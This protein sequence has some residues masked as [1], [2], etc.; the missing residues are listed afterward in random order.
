MRNNFIAITVLAA[1]FF[2]GMPAQAAEKIEP[3]AFE[4]WAKRAD[5]SNV[6]L[7]PD[8]EKLA[9]LKIPTKDGNPILEIY[10]ASDLTA[11]P[12]KMNANPMEMTRFYW[13]T[14]DSIIFSAR[15]QVRDKIDGFNRGVYETTRGLLT[16]DKDPK[17]S[18]WTKIASL[19]S[20]GGG[21]LGPIEAKP[22]KFLTYQYDKGSYY[23]KYFEYDVETG[24][25]KL[26]TRETPKVG[27]FRFDGEGNP[28][29]ASGYDAQSNEFLSYY[30]KKGSN[31]WEVINR[32]HRE[33]FEDWFALG[34]DPLAPSNLLVIAH[35]GENTAG[36]WSFDPENGE[37]KELIYR[38]SDV[39]LTFRGGG[40][41]RHTNRYTNPNEVTAVQYFD[42]RDIKYEWFDGDEKAL[43]EQLMGLIPHADRMNIGSR[44]RDGNSIVVSNS[45]PRDPGTYYLIKNGELKLIG[46]RKPQFASERL[47][48]AEA[49]T[50]KARDG[51]KI[52][53][54]ITIPNGKPPYPLVVMPHGGPFVSKISGYD[55]WA[56]L[57]ANHGY[58]VFEPQYRGSTGYGLDFYQ[59]AFING[60]E[61]GYKMQDDKDDGALYLVDQ[62]LADPEQLAM[63][64]WSYG[65]YAALIAAA[66]ED[67][68]YQCAIAGAAVADNIQQ[69]NYYRNRMAM[70]PTAGSIEQI[71]M[72]EESISPINE[73]KNVNIPLFVIHGDVDQRVPPM[74][75]KKYIK[76]LEENQ[77]PHKKM[78]LK[79]A[80][81]FYD[82]LFY[83]HK[84]KF[85]PALIDFL[86]ND[87]FG[88]DKSLAS[89][90]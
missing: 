80:D 13:A 6:S 73:V 45:G 66:R 59:S 54:F 26:I 90:N 77:I 62:G 72:W 68:I 71:K 19:S 84:M 49:I 40:V 50:Y 81:H 30:R 32:S 48:D 53:G 7:S 29:F 10:D 65:G 57:L 2:L 37:Y 52:T 12:F 46:S 64:G 61:G 78:W 8:G 14:D 9:L 22:N 39:D 74:H 25:R 89:N 79:D 18:K 55:E 86:E 20:S 33:N 16:L 31:D 43:Y 3:Y 70:F 85:Y 58:M 23:P 28:Q 56:Q 44:S 42:G 35:N 5:M 38:R 34:I 41:R 15:Q 36:L 21:L 27:N 1:I 63:F 88:K 75:A 47:A 51:R 17:K 4:E 76:A 69:L 67:Q 11:R 83:R 87:C 82:S 60:G 24:R